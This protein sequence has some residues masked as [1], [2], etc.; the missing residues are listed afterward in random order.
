LLLKVSKEHPVT[1]H[2][3]KIAAYRLHGKNMSNNIPQMLETALFVLKRHSKEIT[4]KAEKESFKK[5]VGFWKTYYTTHLYKG[6][7]SGAFP[8]TFENLYTLLK[9][10]SKLGLKMLVKPGKS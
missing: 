9:H 3:N 8:L 5:G 10:N 4:T 7:R 2:T 1:Y 6:I